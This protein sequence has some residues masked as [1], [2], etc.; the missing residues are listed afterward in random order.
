MKQE[1][2]CPH[3]IPLMPRSAFSALSQVKICIYIFYIFSFSSC[4]LRI[5][6]YYL[7]WAG[8]KKRIHLSP[9]FLST[10]IYFP[11]LPH[12]RPHPCLPSSLLL[13]TAASP[14]LKCRRSPAGY[15]ARTLRLQTQCFAPL[16]VKN[17]IYI[18]LFY[19]FFLSRQLMYR[20][21]CSVCALQVNHLEGL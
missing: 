19:L 2:L 11:L 9:C 13:S 15:S 17:Y 18:I 6:I 7:T 21:T 8:G 3:F 20:C 16:S 12:K 4:R 14:R 10:S 1:T 5:E